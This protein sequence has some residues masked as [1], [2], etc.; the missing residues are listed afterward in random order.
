M[1]KPFLRL[2]G[3]RYES[4]TVCQCSM[5]TALDQ[6]MRIRFLEQDGWVKAYAVECV[7]GTTYWWPYVNYL[8]LA[9]VSPSLLPY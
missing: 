8:P 3:V 9:T 5:C 2:K 6:P 7:N 1:V 4:S